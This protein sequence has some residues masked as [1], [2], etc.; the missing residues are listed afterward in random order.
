[1]TDQKN[2]GADDKKY[3]ALMVEYKK[4]RRGPDREAANLILQQ[5][6]ELGRKGDVSDKAKV[7]AAYL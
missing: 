1:M 6:M 4:A 7:G 3:F 5:V 2:Q